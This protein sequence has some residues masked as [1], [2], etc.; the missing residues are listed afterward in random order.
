ML[1]LQPRQDANAEEHYVTAKFLWSIIAGMRML[2]LPVD[3]LAQR[4]QVSLTDLLEPERRVALPS[5][6]RLCDAAVAHAGRDTLGL[7]L[8]ALY[9]L[10]GFGIVDLL[11]QSS[12]TL[13][14]CLA[15]MCRY[16]S[17]Y[18]TA[19]QTDIVTCHDEVHIV[20]RYACDRPIPRYV[21]E[22]N[23]A[24]LVVIGRKLTGHQLPVQSAWFAQPAPADASM[25][26]R[27]FRCPLF[28]NARHDRLVLPREALDLR[29]GRAD[30]ALLSTLAA[31]AEGML[32]KS[33]TPL[34]LTSTTHRT[35]R[36]L[37]EEP[38]GTLPSIA[39][40]A[41]RLGLSE[42]TLQRKLQE[43]GTS[44]ATLLDNARKDL[45]RRCLA[46]RDMTLTETA[47]RLG[48][49]DVRAFRR[50]FKRWTGMTAQAFAAE[51]ETP[52]QRSPRLA[53]S[54]SLNPGS[55]YASSP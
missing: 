34:D 7:E 28:W 6:L 2:G 52:V 47:R 46:R 12:T 44:F 24:T 41:K 9:E 16:E 35:R 55:N 17:L 31:H 38:G 5:A 14:E 29:I 49:T 36:V 40:V 50:A 37:V 21:S 43:E 22:N 42:R 33:R 13:R 45:A 25:H 26:D 30:K 11:A 51:P 27:I 19:M 1:T 10:G 23:L 3:G 15:H 20:H 8:A 48:Y 4:A 18:Q 32:D 53:G 54:A 39:E